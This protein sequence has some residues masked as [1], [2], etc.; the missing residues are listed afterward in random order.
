MGEAGGPGRV[1]PKSSSA[2]MAGR[3]PGADLDERGVLGEPEVWSAAEVKSSRLQGGGQ[4]EGRVLP[5]ARPLRGAG[6]GPSLVIVPLPVSKYLT[7]QAY[8]E[9][10]GPEERR[11]PSPRSLTGLALRGWGPSGPGGRSPERQPRAD[12]RL[13]R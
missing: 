12:T 5:A 2:Q 13:H 3:R 1:R 11:F 6:Q 7:F 8:L 10:T 9:G 4:E